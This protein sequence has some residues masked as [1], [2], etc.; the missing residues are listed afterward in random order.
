M[1]NCLG[2]LSKRLICSMCDSLEIQCSETLVEDR[3]HHEEFQAL[4]NPDAFIKIFEMILKNDQNQIPDSQPVVL[5]IIVRIA[6]WL[7]L[8]ISIR[9]PDDWIGKFLLCVWNT[10]STSG[11][12]AR[13]HFNRNEIIR[14]LSHSIFGYPKNVVEH[15][16]G[17]T[18]KPYPIDW[19]G[20]SL[21]LTSFEH[22]S[23]G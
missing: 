7:I 20:A 23:N 21:L 3:D 18:C 13:F 17:C 11:H 8:N 9:W 16:S 14:L 10:L 2:D 15:S 19:N 4:F 12:S 5:N 1:I 6:E 22:L